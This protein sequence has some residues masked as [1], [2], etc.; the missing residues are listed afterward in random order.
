MEI[1]KL[2]VEPREQTGTRA[3]RLLRQSGYIPAI[4]YSSAQPT[5]NLKLSAG[6]WSKHL[7]D[8]LNLVNLEFP[9]GATQMAAL[10]EIQ[11]DPLTLDVLHVDLLRVRMD[12]ATE[13]HVFLDYQGTP[14]G[15]KDG[16]VRTVLSEYLMVECLPSDVPDS[17]PVDISAL[18]I[19]ESLHAEHVTLPDGVKL[20]TDPAV[21]LISVAAVR[22]VEEVKPVEAVE[23]EAA[24]EGE[25][26]PAEKEEETDSRP[27]GR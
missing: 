7:T 20:L 16:G 13:F 19:G 18:K 4:L 26:K 5:E 10:R 22:V 1:M 8:Q 23:A 25:E 3:A 11:R 17:I 27:H 6:M 2:A 9:D 15:V 21:T 24:E 12:E 14:Q